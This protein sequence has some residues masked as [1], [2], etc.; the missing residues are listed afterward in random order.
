MLEMRGSIDR[1]SFHFIADNCKV[2]F[3]NNCI[4]DLDSTFE[5]D[6]EVSSFDGE[7]EVSIGNY[8]IEEYITDKV[9]FSEI[10][11][12]K[13]RIL[14]S[15]NLLEGGKGFEY[16]D[17]SL[18][19]YNGIL[20]RI[21]FNRSY[22]LIMLEFNSNQQGE[23]ADVKNSLDKI[24]NA[25]KVQ[26]HIQVINI[27]FISNSHQRYENGVPIHGLQSGCN[28][29]IK[30]EENVTGCEGYNIRSGEGYI[31]TV[32]NLDGNHPMWGN[33][34]QM[35]PKPMKMISQ[36]DA[37]TVLRGYKCEVMSP[38]GWVDFNGADYGLTIFHKYGEIDKCTLHMHDRNIDIEYYKGDN[39]TAQKT[40]TKTKDTQPH[41]N[42]VTDSQ[43]EELEKK[44][45]R[46]VFELR[47]KC[48][49]D[50]DIESLLVIAK[51]NFTHGSAATNERNFPEM[52]Y[53]YGRLRRIEDMKD[54]LKD[55]Q[56]YFMFPG[57]PQSCMELA[58]TLLEIGYKFPHL[59]EQEIAYLEK[60]YCDSKY[61][62]LFDI[63]MFDCDRL[64]RPLKKFDK[65]SLNIKNSNFSKEFLLKVFDSF[66]ENEKLDDSY[67]KMFVYSRIQNKIIKKTYEDTGLGEYCIVQPICSN[68]FYNLMK[69]K[70]GNDCADNLSKVL[71]FG[72]T[73]LES[74]KDY[75]CYLLDAKSIEE[76]AKSYFDDIS[77]VE[78]VKCEV[79]KFWLNK[80]NERTIKLL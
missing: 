13:D 34:V 22:P 17:M 1:K 71:C 2:W 23:I 69:N 63:I 60:K 38:F 59:S 74:F 42:N 37:Q 56:I 75:N 25:K 14:W 80:I 67:D 51:H 16:S 72:N 39:T 62:E 7:V 78:N 43:L 18:F 55:K 5:I 15:N 19:Y 79:S 52:C 40:K 9:S 31:V 21:Y 30:I 36:T 77:K 48:A 24:R 46:E 3:Q 11:M 33:N 70:F 26:A 41:K 4:V 73:D 10:S 29:A 28:R 27:T 45:W 54:F 8:E 35:T 6:A 47:R 65:E 61:F 53:Y 32:L 49:N 58:Q 66:I 12:L 64:S 76:A 20:S 68:D 44:N 57:L 50:R